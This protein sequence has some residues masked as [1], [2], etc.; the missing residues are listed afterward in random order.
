M[1]KTLTLIGLERPVSIIVSITA[2]LRARLVSL[3]IGWP[4]LIRRSQWGRGPLLTTILELTRLICR[5]PVIR[6]M[7]LM[8]AC[9]L[10]PYILLAIDRLKE[11]G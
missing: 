11:S 8:A 5:P 2:I 3:V 1:A 10:V 4:L 7:L 9:H 6:G